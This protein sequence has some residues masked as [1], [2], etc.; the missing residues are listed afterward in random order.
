[1]F[2]HYIVHRLCKHFIDCNQGINRFFFHKWT[3]L[4]QIFGVI[5]STDYVNIFFNISQ[6]QKEG[7][8]RPI[9]IRKR[10]EKLPVLAQN[11]TPT[12][13]GAEKNLTKSLNGPYSPNFFLHVVYCDSRVVFVLLKFGAGVR[14]LFF[15]WDTVTE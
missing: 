13:H 12:R 14:Y 5:W 8:A 3:T 4:P 7:T 9:T 6:M 11:L 2:C 15:S 10:D 1:M